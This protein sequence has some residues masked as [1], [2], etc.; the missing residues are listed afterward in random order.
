MC[1]LCKDS[2]ALSQCHTFKHLSN[3]ETYQLV[4]KNKLCIYCLINEHMIKNCQSH[5]CKICEKWYNTLIHRKKQHS[6]ECENRDQESALQQENIQ[7]TYHTFKET[8]VTCVLLATA[9]IKIKGCKG[10]LHT[11]D[12]LL[13]CGSQSNFITVS[14][15]R[16][17]GL[18]QIRNQ[19]PITGINNATS[20]MNYNV[21]LEITSMKSDY[22]N[23]LH[24]YAKNNKQNAND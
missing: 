9:Q 24:C 8:P 15:V 22:T 18:E 19:I 6:Q 17:L 12:A 7:A 20:V 2:H 10:K 3:E 23:E 11:F 21:N 4:K 1:E 13:V 5:G 14:A 16:S